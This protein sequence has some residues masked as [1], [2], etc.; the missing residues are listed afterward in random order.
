MVGI[1]YRMIWCLQPPISSLSQIYLGRLELCSAVATALLGD[2]LG[3][4]ETVV[5]GAI[6]RG[7]MGLVYLPTFD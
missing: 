4:R 7:S 6:P 1:L 5:G 3:G 2:V